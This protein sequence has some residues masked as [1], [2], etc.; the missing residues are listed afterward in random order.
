MDFQTWKHVFKLDPAKEISDDVIEQLCTSG[1][2]A[3][4]VGGSDDVTMEGVVDLLTRVRRFSVPIVLEIS[5]LESITLGFD[6]YFIP[7]VLNST[8]ASFFKDLHHAALKEYGAMMN[9][10]QMIVEGYC[11]LNEQCKVAQLTS[12]NTKLD[13]DDV[14]AYAQMA[15]HLFHMPIFYMEYSGTYG[16]SD[17]VYAASRELNNT[18]L[19]YGG[20]ITTAEQAREMAYYADMVV[21]GNI[22]YDDPEM[23]VKTVKAVRE[24][25]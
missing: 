2:D 4:L 7:S 8:N 24:V 14:V 21:I 22:I 6:Y 15:E 23:A 10:D 11:V 19:I 17:L 18:K 12:A 9:W 1:T 25:C 13:E 5:N 20:G 3:I 16:D